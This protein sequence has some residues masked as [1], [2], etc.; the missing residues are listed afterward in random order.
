MTDV[1]VADPDEYL[2]LPAWVYS[3]SG[4]FAAERERVLAPSWQVVC[5]LNDVPS[6][7]D[8]HTLLEAGSWSSFDKVPPL[9]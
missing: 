4:F 1:T 7:G 6:V 2:G 5:H 9:P 3:N 8:F